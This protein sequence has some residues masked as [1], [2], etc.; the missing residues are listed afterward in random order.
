M[1]NSDPFKRKSHK[2][3]KS[4][5]LTK[6]RSLPNIKI[7]HS[8]KSKSKQKPSQK[9][10]DTREQ[11][12]E[13]KIKRMESELESIRRLDK[14]SKS[15]ELREVVKE[16]QQI[17]LEPTPIEDI[18]DTVTSMIHDKK[19]T[20]EQMEVF[21]RQGLSIKFPK[22][23]IDG[24]VIKFQFLGS[25]ANGNVYKLSYK[26]EQSALKVLYFA[27]WGD[28]E[29]IVDLSEGSKNE[30][31]RE[32]YILNTLS[33]IPNFLKYHSLTMDDH[34]V[35]IFME[36]FSGVTIHAFL[37]NFKVTPEI[38]ALGLKTKDEA[39]KSLFKQMSV[40]IFNMHEK[41]IVHNDFNRENTL[42]NM[43][44]M[45]YRIID[46]GFSRCY[47]DFGHEICMRNDERLTYE[48]SAGFPDFPQMA[49]WRDKDCSGP[50]CTFLD[51]K[52]GD[53]WALVVLFCNHLGYQFSEL[54]AKH[55]K[56]ITS[57]NFKTG[58]PGIYNRM[59]GES[60]PDYI[61]RDI[62]K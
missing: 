6:A 19:T 40:S 57:D 10:L 25:G 3:H 34:G 53:Y 18:V 62:T 32:I 8:S 23:T 15:E 13:E 26:N 48:Y 9:F 61:M 36:C 56:D 20:K 11:I 58:F 49:P 41:S 45:E 38:S 50:G 35:Y 17:Q 30:I 7:K 21:E 52:R 37:H 27:P 54:N 42:V 60:L 4:K 14:S 12:L 1:A 31:Q 51:L 29:R 28:K 22:K 59:V 16:I 33:T 5:K 39:F 24:Q 44:T 43:R 47:G 46:F 55:G 2:S